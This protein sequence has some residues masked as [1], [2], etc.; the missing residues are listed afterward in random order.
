MKTELSTSSVEASSLGTV[1][2]WI[3]D[4]LVFPSPLPNGEYVCVCWGLGWRPYCC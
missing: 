2:V 4:A 3:L 1:F